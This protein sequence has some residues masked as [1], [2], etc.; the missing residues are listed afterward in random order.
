[1]GS[2]SSVF[3][4]VTALSLVIASTRTAGRPEEDDG[5]PGFLKYPHDPVTDA[6]LRTRRNPSSQAFLP[7]ANLHRNPRVIPHLISANNL[8]VAY[9]EAGRLEQA[10]PLLEQTLTDSRRLL[11]EEYPLTKAVAT[12]LQRAKPATGGPP[13]RRWWRTRAE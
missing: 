7:D 4:A 5:N 9:R 3:L 6:E 2:A 8:A 13:R 11:G 1:V 10:I 12:N